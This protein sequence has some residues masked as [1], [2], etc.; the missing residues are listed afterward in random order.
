MARVFCLILHAGAHRST[1]PGA[2]ATCRY[3]RLVDE[4]LV[5][6]SLQQNNRTGVLSADVDAVGRSNMDLGW[7]LNISF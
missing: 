5:T 6:S 7:A 1:E 3:G 2:G 4:G